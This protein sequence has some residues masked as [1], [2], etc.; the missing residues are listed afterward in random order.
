MFWLFLRLRFEFLVWRV[1]ILGIGWNF[2]RR[3]KKGRAL[4]SFGRDFLLRGL[5]GEK[6][7]RE[8]VGSEMNKEKVR[9]R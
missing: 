5:G 8:R 3:W 4:G 7:D 2:G 9:S 1:G 6:L